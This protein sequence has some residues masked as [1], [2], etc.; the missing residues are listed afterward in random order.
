MVRVL[1]FP[2]PGQGW[3]VFLA[4]TTGTQPEKSVAPIQ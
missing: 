2:A 4:L 3:Q 1:D